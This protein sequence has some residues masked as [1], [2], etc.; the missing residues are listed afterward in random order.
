MVT[1]TNGIKMIRVPSGAV[2]IYKNAGF[3][4]LSESELKDKQEEFEEEYITPRVFNKIDSHSNKNEDSKNEDLIFVEELLEKPLSQ[5]TN[6]EVKDFVRIKGIDTSG[7]QKVS[8]VRGIIKNY[9]E[10]EL[11]NKN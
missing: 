1:L 2:G 3:H 8:Q 5:W 9:L 6:E 7:A 10:E 11:K 4:V